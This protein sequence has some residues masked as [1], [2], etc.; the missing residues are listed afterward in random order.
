MLCI[1][2]FG[3][4]EEIWLQNCGLYYEEPGT[5]LLEGWICIFSFSL[6]L[7]LFLCYKAK[8]DSPKKMQTYELLIISFLLLSIL[9]W[10]YYFINLF[11]GILA[12][13][14][15]FLFVVAFSNIFEYPEVQTQ[16]WEKS[17]NST[18]NSSGQDETANLIRDERDET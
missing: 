1:S 5:G 2:A 18:T 8:F 3:V 13:L 11:V 15:S 14:A 16:D 12:V 9:F 7:C 6:V 10:G 17:Q 4:G